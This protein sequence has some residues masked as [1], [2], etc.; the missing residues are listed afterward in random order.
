[1]KQQTA[2]TGCS[3]TEYTFEKVGQYWLNN[4]STK[5]VSVSIYRMVPTIGARKMKRVSAKIRVKGLPSYPVGIY[6]KAQDI[7][8][9][10]NARRMTPPA[11]KQ[12]V[13]SCKVQQK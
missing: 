12:T 5:E 9:A 13:T 7:C 2:A 3:A 10:L 11:K 4:A 8:D 1:M 6:K